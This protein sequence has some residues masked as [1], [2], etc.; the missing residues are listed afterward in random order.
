MN[1]DFINKSRE[2]Q[3]KDFEQ[4]RFYASK[5]CRHCLGTGKESWIVDLK[6]YKVCRCVLKNIKA[7]RERGQN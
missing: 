4:I 3:N 5:N 1:I 6:Q 2:E 7:L